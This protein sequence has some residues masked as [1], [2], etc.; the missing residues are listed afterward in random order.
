MRD[1]DA[2][3]KTE[4]EIKSYNKHTHV[5]L[6]EKTTSVINSIVQHNNDTFT[7]NKV[8][9][10]VSKPLAWRS[11]SYLLIWVKLKKDLDRRKLRQN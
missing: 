1:V 5:E 3:S 10:K 6:S 4:N 2:S 11:S 7:K 8:E 9:A